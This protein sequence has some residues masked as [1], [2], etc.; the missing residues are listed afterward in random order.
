MKLNG[1]ELPNVVEIW[2]EDI[3][4]SLTLWWEVRP[5]MKTVSTGKSGKNFEIEGE[6]GGEAYA[7]AGKRVL[8][9]D[10][11]TRLEALLQSADGTRG[12]TS[13][14]GRPVVFPRS[15]DGSLV[16]PQ[17]GTQLLGGLPKPGLA[18][19]P[20]SSSP[21][22]GPAGPDLVSSIS[23]ET[24]PLLF[25]LSSRKDPGRAKAKES[26]VESGLDCRGLIQPL[27]KVRAQFGEA[28]PSVLSGTSL[29]RGP[30]SDILSF[31]VKDGLQKQI[32]EELHSE[33]RSK[34]DFALMEEA[35]RY[36]NTF[37]PNGML[38]SGLYSSFFF[39][40][41]SIGGVLRLFRGWLRDS[42]GG[43]TMLHVQCPGVCR[44][45]DRHS[46]GADGGKQ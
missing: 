24:G 38:V 28:R 25:G 40:S 36:G 30:N 32:E 44:E 42:P 26:F 13:G 6:V 17:G 4:Y 10:D 12:Q 45:G 41:D 27:A 46:L 37:I 20:W 23:F 29:L 21:I 18:E 22:F 2:V 9:K 14:L 11:D 19:V 3:C 8:E 1:E 39:W 7:C 5:V 15:L 31:W 16:G 35:L 33:E 43:N 34:T